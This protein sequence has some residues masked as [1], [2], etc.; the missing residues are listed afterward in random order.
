MHTVK[1]ATDVTTATPTAGVRILTD[2]TRESTMTVAIAI[3]GGTARTVQAE[4]AFAENGP[5][6]PVGTA[7]TAIGS[8]I[9]RVPA[10]PYVRINPSANTGST[11]NAWAAFN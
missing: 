4:V 1:L 6:F 5:W 9:E 3:A 11:V 2:Q 8:F 7:Q 10:A